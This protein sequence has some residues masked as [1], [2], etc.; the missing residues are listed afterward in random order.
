MK[1][2]QS[3]SSRKR[4]ENVPRV[5]DF[6]TASCSR[7]TDVTGSR[8]QMS[9]RIRPA[10]SRRFTSRRYRT[11]GSLWSRSCGSA[12]KKTC[13]SPSNFV[14]VYSPCRG[15]RDAVVEKRKEEKPKREVG[16]KLMP[17]LLRELG[18]PHRSSTFSSLRFFLPTSS[19]ILTTWIRSTKQSG[20]W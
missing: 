3:G 15:E 4:T 9:R 6:P 17:S 1:A 18:R 8:Y 7:E 16:A 2:P 14:E 19:A 10:S 13:A 5:D 11:W 12:V 20:M